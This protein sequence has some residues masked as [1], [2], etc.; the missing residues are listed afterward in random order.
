VVT[1]ISVGAFKMLSGGAVSGGG[2]ISVAGAGAGGKV[3]RAEEVMR[4]AGSPD[5]C[6]E[7]TA[8]AAHPDCNSP[9]QVFLTPVLKK[10]GDPGYVEPEED[11]RPPPNAVRMS[12]A[13]PPAGN[14]TLQ[15]ESGQSLCQLPCS[16]W[17]VRDKTYLLQ[18]D[19]D[20][21]V[22]KIKMPRVEYAPG[23]KVDVQVLEPRGSKGLGI[24]ATITGG[25]GMVAGAAMAF[26]AGASEEEG[27]L[28]P[29]L[30]VIGGG[31]ALLTTGIVVLAYSRG[32]KPEF[33]LSSPGDA[34]ALEPHIVFGPGSAR[35]AF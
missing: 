17:I 19:T 10:P 15:E 12:F 8:E 32:Y 29:G 34:A 11:T 13:A 16:R 25:V 1:G 22:Q 24:A 5:Q 33:R 9:I 18:L 35:G 21:G 28:V 31:A 20:S 7:A 26:L 30:A 23:Q 6:A 2:G 27:L 14:W 3:S 4:Q